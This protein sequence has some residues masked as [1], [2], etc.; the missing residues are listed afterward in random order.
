MG[1]DMY[2]HEKETHSSQSTPNPQGTHLQSRG[3]ELM[4]RDQQEVL[5][6]Q[7]VLTCDKE[8]VFTY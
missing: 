1:T 8:N 4:K 7:Y 2:V 5:L 6:Y 3:L